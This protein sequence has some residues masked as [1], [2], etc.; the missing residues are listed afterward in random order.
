M[1]LVRRIKKEYHFYITSTYRVLFMNK[2]IMLAAGLCLFCAAFSFAQSKLVADV[3]RGVVQAKFVPKTSLSSVV[4][5]Y[6]RTPGVTHF[7]V[8]GEAMRAVRFSRNIFVKKENLFLPEGT[9]A[10]ITPAGKINVFGPEDEVPAEIKKGMDAAFEAENPGFFELMEAFAAAAASAPAAKAWNGNTMYEA[11]ADLAKDIDAY[12]NG[13]SDEVFTRKI[14][15]AV[16]KVYRIPVDGIYYH[17]VGR[18]GRYLSPEKDLLLFYSSRHDGRAINEGQLVFGG[19][20]DRKWEIFF[21]PR[22]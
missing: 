21:D 4:N 8:N 7:S 11:Q 13:Q 1:S 16:T 19:V 3:T 2:K 14:D 22:P 20:T 12:Y 9:L 15:G 18:A 10:V 17:P 6:L 5:G